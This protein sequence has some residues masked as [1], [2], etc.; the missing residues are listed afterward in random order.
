M[1]QNIWILSD[2]DTKANDKWIK[3]YQNC[4]SLA[5]NVKYFNIRELAGIAIDTEDIEAVHR[6]F[7]DFGIAK[8]LKYLHSKEDTPDCILGF[9]L[10]GTI[11]WRYALETKLSHLFAISSTR[12][13]YETQVPHTAIYL[14]FGAL[15]PYKPT[16]E[17]FADKGLTHRLQAHAGHT[18][19]K[20]ETYIQELVKKIKLIGN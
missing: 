20:E 19:Y 8:A 15:D 11:A 16:Q 10:G 13:R 6:D 2:I 4:L 7:I 3:E 17:W 18:F 14:K 9:S 1:R 12:L 5:F